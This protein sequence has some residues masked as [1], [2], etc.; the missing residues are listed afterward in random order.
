M[1]TTTPITAR[2]FIT[3]DEVRVNHRIIVGASRAVVTSTRG[4]DGGFIVIGYIT[5]G[6]VNGSMVLGS[7]ALVT[8]RPFTIIDKT[9]PAPVALAIG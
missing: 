8:V 7:S 5:T 2:T 9:G 3:A 4:I 1:N 6:G